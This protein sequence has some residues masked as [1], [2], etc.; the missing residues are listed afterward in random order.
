V[1]VMFCTE[2]AI[3]PPPHRLLYR[4]ALSLPD[5]HLLLDGLT[6]SAPSHSAGLNLLQN[7]LALALESMRGRQCLSFVRLEKLQDVWLDASGN[8]CMFVRNFFLFDSFARNPLI[9]ILI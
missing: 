6:F 8:V 7:P 4:G 1:S 3:H 2:T 9:L 5:S